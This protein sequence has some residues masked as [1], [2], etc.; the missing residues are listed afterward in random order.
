MLVPDGLQILQ[1]NVHK[2]KERTDSMLNNP[3]TK[4]YTVLLLQEP[5]W[6]EYK[7]S[8]PT[9]QAW[10]LFEPIIK[11]T[12]PRA[13]IYINK[14][15][16]AA[17][18]ILPFPDVVAVQITTRDPKPMLIINVYKPCDE[19]RTESLHRCIH[20]HLDMHKFG[21]IIIAGDFNLHHPLWNP[22]GYPRHDDEANDLVEMMADFGMS[23][24]VPKGTVTYP[25]AETAIDL[26]WGNDA[27]AS[28]LL[29]CQIAEDYDHGSDHL[30]IETAISA[31][32]TIIDVQ[33]AYNYAETNWEEFKAKL[34]SCLPRLETPK[35]AANI[36]NFIQSLIAAI[37]HSI[38]SSTPQKKPC[39]HSKR[40]WTPHLTRLRRAANR[41]RNRYRRTR[42]NIAR[43]EWRERA[44]EYTNTIAKEKEAKWREY[45]SNADGK[46]IWKVKKYIDNAQTPTFIPTLD[47]TAETTEQKTSLF[48]ETFFP[49]PP[50]AKLNDIAQTLYPA[51]VHCVT[52]I[53]LRQVRQAVGKVAPDKA[54]RPDEITNRVLKRALPHIEQHI[55]TLMQAS[56]DLA[57]FP[58]VFKE[59]RTIVMRK[60]GKE[61]YTKAKSY[62]PIALENTLGKVMESIIADIISY[63]T[64]ANDLLPP[65]H[66]GG[67]PGRSA[68]DAMMV[69]TENIYK[70]WKKGKI[71][72]AVFLDVA[73]AFNNVHHKRLIH[74]LHKRRIPNKVV[75]WI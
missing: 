68:E 5:H 53:S 22:N 36:D 49:A 43:I 7:K 61:D 48:K 6:S 62:R 47:N 58:K 12:Q 3:D 14:N 28:T 39:P 29:K 4:K 16:N 30:P 9:H 56:L 40:W 67:R 50:P 35:N 41:A 20:A 25:N 71:Y 33:P 44:N 60:H 10:M 15:L 74:N 27:V 69:L 52:K 75:D 42:N 66:Y 45:V 38:E 73:G 19:N 17:Q 23:P 32:P 34:A 57:H 13:A 64:E 21:T 72:S 31:Q 37:T 51:K 24:L 55:C 63:L 65:H 18:I 26:V 46:S 2:N 8:S 70:A 1:N 54:P 11:D 59:T